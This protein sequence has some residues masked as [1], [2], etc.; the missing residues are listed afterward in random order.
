LEDRLL[1]SKKREET[2]TIII[3]TEEVE[4]VIMIE[5][6]VEAEVDTTP[7]ASKELTMSK[8]KSLRRRLK[9]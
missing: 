2:G 5:V 7:Q 8:F 3:I 1:R 9:F 6:E 4:V